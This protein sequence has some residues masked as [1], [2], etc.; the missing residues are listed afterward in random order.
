M[1]MD[2]GRYEVGNDEVGLRLDR[3][4][5]D[6]RPDHSRSKWSRWIRDGLVLIDGLPAHPSARLALGSVV[7]YELP[8]ARDERLEAEAIPLTLIFEDRDVLVLDKPAG[9]VVHPGSGVDRGTLA[10]GLLHFDPKLA[11]V[12]GPAR[13][14]IV[15]RLDVG[16]S[17]VMV[18]ARSDSAHR[19]LSAQF[20]DR[21]VTK[22]YQAIVWGRPRERSGEIE[23]PIGRDPR[24]RVKMAVGGSAA[25]PAK[26]RY[27]V[28]EEVPGFARVDVEIFT[29][30]THQIRVHLEHLG[31]PIVGDKLYGGDRSRGI[32][33]A[34]R[35]NTV[36]L[37]DRPALHAH[38]LAFDHPRSGKRMTF[39]VAMPEEMQALWRILRG[40]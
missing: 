22:V 6:H 30:R 32:Q 35:R 20:R 21:E 2:S 13:A 11:G 4:L 25:R 17:G 38:R 12:G 37:F 8:V 9:L 3:F 15:H 24:R 10:A 40:E 27:T 7:T 34:I 39:E 23:A 16:T 14:G 31:Y 33:D 29:G 36:K 18:I 28:V 1:A 5:A 19:N 26:S